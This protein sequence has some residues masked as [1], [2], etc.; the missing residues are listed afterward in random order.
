MATIN[1]VKRTQISLNCLAIT[2]LPP[3]V[4][5]NHAPCAIK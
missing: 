2:K 5:M 4:R 3:L 1:T